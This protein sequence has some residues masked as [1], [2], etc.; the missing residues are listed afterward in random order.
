MTASNAAGSGYSAAVLANNPRSYWR[1]DETTGQ[2]VDAM[3]YANGTYVNAPSRGVAGL[4][5][6]DPDQAVSLDGSTQ[7][8]DVTA[9]P[10]WTPASF[11]IEVLVKP[12]QLP[13]NKTIWST[14]GPNFT[15]WWLNTGPSGQVRM[16]IGDGTAWRFDDPNVV[17]SANTRYDIVVTYDG[18]NAR[19]YVNGALVSTGPAA[20][21]NGSV[22]ANPLRFG[23]YSTGPGQYWP[24]VLDDASFYPSV[25]SSA[26]VSAH[27]QAGLAP[28]PTANSTTTSVVAA[29]AP[30]NQ[31]APTISGTPTVGQALTAATGTWSGTAPISYGYQWQSG[32]STTGTFTN[33]AGATGSS[34][35]P[36]T[37]GCGVVRA[38]DGDGEQCGRFVVCAV[39]G[40]GAGG[41][42]F[43]SAGH[44][45]L[46]GRCERRR[47]GCRSS[48]GDECRVSAE[49]DGVAVYER[50][51]SSRS[52]SETCS[53]S[54]RSSTG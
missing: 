25:L 11:S 54:T 20:S 24:G 53:R 14:I 7:Y 17:L 30:S 16:F 28:P 12:S 47:R 51:R 15:G 40:R 23:A 52:A 39:G 44:G 37:W 49:R 32:A 31:S 5:T 10:A 21:M 9:D 3:G 29:A 41:G 18:T 33:I 1:F 27:Y 35:S 4:L 13:V 26:Q 22:G 50:R 38:G 48:G 8:L 43:R 2:L 42:V 6:G 45:V 36:V 46:L 34:Y 19:L